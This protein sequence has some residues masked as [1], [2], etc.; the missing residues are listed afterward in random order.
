MQSLVFNKV[1]FNVEIAILSTSRSLEGVIA[2][3][4]DSVEKFNSMYNNY[5]ELKNFYGSE[6]WF[7][8]MEIEYELL[9]YYQ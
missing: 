4:I 5:I 8:Y 6:K 2:L 3:D 9:T 1:I 7:E